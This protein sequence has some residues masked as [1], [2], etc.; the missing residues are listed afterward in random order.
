MPENSC[1][2]CPKC[3]GIMD[4]DANGVCICRDCG[5]AFVPSGCEGVFIPASIIGIHKRAPTK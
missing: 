5:A 2:H 4:K 1:P 3:K